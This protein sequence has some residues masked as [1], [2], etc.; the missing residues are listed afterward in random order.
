MALRI[1]QISDTHLSPLH[2]EFSANFE[3][4]AAHLR[5]NPPDLIVHTGDVSAHGELEAEGEADLRFAHARHAEL[6]VEFLAVPGNHDVGNDPAA[7]ERNGAD[8]FRVSRWNDVFGA[9]RFV[10]DA[11]G[12]RLI[13]LNSLITQTELADSQFD[14]LASALDGAQGRRIALFM[15]KPLCVEE[16][17]ESGLTY[18]SVLPDARRRMLDLLDAAP[19][20][21]IA[22]GHIHQ[23][24]DRGVSEGLRQIWAP[25]VAFFVGDAWQQR[26]GDKGLGY[27]EHL[28][29]P[30]GRHECRLINLDGFA[31]H[32]IGEMPDVYGPQAPIVPMPNPAS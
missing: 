29:H 26:M 25:A 3:V 30:D 6:G 28:L 2:P 4:L 20:A 16:L 31:P 27:V 19:P 22:S 9:D 10:R 8:A 11:P 24:L 21:F 7:T 13:G 12:W 1:A 15:H 18:W 14:F 32:D 5:A 17:A 23:W